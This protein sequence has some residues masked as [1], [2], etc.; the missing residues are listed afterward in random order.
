MFLFH[1]IPKITDY[2]MDQR[3]YR[4]SKR[5]PMYP[6]GYGLSYSKFSFHNLNISPQNMSVVQDIT[7]YVYVEN[8]GPFDGEEVCNIIYTQYTGN[9]L[10]G[11]LTRSH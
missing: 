9:I 4:Y 3:T 2:S 8:M 11:K 6:F 10:C 7:V 1:Q 5:N